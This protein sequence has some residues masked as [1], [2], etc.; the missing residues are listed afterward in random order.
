MSRASFRRAAA[1]L[2]AAGLA[3]SSP[4][5]AQTGT[6]GTIEFAPSA[7][8]TVVASDGTPLLS[9]YSVSVYLAGQSTAIQTLNLGKPSPDADGKIR[10]EFLSKLTVSL[11]PG[12]LYETRVSASG[13]GGTT[14]SAVSNQFQA[15][16]C[17]ASLGAASFSA[18]SASAT[19][20][21]AVT[22]LVGCAWTAASNAAWLTVTSGASGSGPGTVGFAVAA[23]TSSSPR[24]AALTIGG[25]TFTV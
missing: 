19:S 21:V 12:Q 3:Y 16:A 1:L 23:N 6:T 4:A 22:T 8:H 5:F 14:V 24:S 20:S 2:V 13:P 10:V 25:V 15:G 11:T 18:T 7:D 17:T 9:Q